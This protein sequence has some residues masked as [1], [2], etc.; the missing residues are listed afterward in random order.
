MTIDTLVEQARERDW[1]RHRPAIKCP[2]C[3]SEKVDET[4]TGY[5]CAKCEHT[6]EGE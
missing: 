5:K 6:W 4:R 1:E 2:L 3:A